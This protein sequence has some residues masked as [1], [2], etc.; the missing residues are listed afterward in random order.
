MREARQCL[1]PDPASVECLQEANASQSSVEVAGAGGGG[2][3]RGVWAFFPGGE[4][5]LELAGVVAQ[6]R[7]SPEIH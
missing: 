6:L 7:D 2:V 3:E 4:H 1:P 5:V